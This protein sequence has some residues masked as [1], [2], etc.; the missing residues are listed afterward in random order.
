MVVE[1]GIEFGSPSVT[2]STYQPVLIESGLGILAK[3]EP[4]LFLHLR[5]PF[6]LFAERILKS[7]PVSEA[8]VS[9]ECVM[10]AIR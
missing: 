7:D 6:L 4:K 3:V 10:I 8:I 9:V 5:Q 1:E 2:D